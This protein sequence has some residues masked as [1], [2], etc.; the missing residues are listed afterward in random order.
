MLLYATGLTLT[1]L[2]GKE[3]LEEADRLIARAA[4]RMPSSE[5]P[6]QT[7]GYLAEI[8]ETVYG[9]RGGLERALALYRRAWLLNRPLEQ[10]ENR[11]NLDLNIGNIAYLLGSKATAWKFYSDRLAAKIPFDNPDTEL[12]FQ[13][14][15]AEVAFQM[16]EKE[17][18]ITGYLRALQLTE[19]RLNP[20]RPL[21]LFGRLTRR[22]VERLFSGSGRSA[23][24]ESALSEQQSITAELERLGAAPPEAPPSAG[25][26][27][28]DKT[29]RSLLERERALLTSAPSWNK[30]ARQKRCRTERHGHRR[31]KRAGCGAAPGGNGGGDP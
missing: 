6:P 2:P 29:M 22:V 11:A 18:P 10:P 25:W 21:D 24:A 9:E 1:Y 4:D 28:F 16:R 31:G 30:D 5:Y 23:A 17:A 3:P 19:T 20:S 13:Q 7:R 27:G 15:Y 26:S 8:D 14:R 12:I